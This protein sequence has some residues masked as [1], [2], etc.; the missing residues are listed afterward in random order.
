MFRTSIPPKFVARA[1]P[2]TLAFCLFFAANAEASELNEDASRVER[3]WVRAS[4]TVTRMRPMFLASGE[5]LPV[6]LPLP[7]EGGEQGCTSVGVLGTR[8]TDFVLALAAQNG[9]LAKSQD[10]SQGTRI[11]SNAG[12]AMLARCGA[13]RQELRNLVVRM[14]SPQAA[15]EVLVASGFQA[16]P[17]FASLLPERAPGTTE[18]TAR[19][20][21]PP[22]VAPLKRRVSMATRMIRESGGEIADTSQLSPDRQGK[23]MNRIYLNS[24][25]HRLVAMPQTRFGRWLVSADT[26]MELRDPMNNQV[27]ARDRSYATDAI[28]EFCVGT[29][30]MVD[31]VITGVPPKGHVTLMHGR[32]TISRG[33]PQ[34]WPPRAQA[35]ISHAML[36]RRGPTLT[37]QPVWEGR[38]VTGTTVLALPVEPGAC[39]L[40]AA[41]AASGD[42]RAVQVAAQVGPRLAADNGGGGIQAGVISFCAGNQRV[43]RMEIDAIGS[44]IRWVAGAWKVARAP[45]GVEVPL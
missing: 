24:G 20:P 4:F 37:E 22:A 32:W 42:S 29:G 10:S 15:I 5:A 12:S 38:G 23:L 25:C 7:N 30:K 19:P 36:R 35:E 27:V 41:G 17:S 11:G 43:V 16:A 9:S 31:V 33:I 1:F 3:A 14:K 28:I 6:V 40:F 21:V 13:A 26:D 39:Y 18:R 45:L 8:T 44:R 34:R 2:L